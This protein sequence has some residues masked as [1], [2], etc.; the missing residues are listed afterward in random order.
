MKPAFTCSRTARLLMTALSLLAAWGAASAAAVYSSASA[1]TFTLISPP[2]FT[3]TDHLPS[4]SSA[5]SGNATAAIGTH[6][7]SPDGVHP[8]T[9]AN[10]VSGSAAY[11][12]DSTSFAEVKSGHHFLVPR[13]DGRGDP[14][15]TVVIP[16]TFEISWDVDL[17]I[18]RPGY[19]FAGGG[20][21][22]ALAGFREGVTVLTLDPGFP[23]HLV[24]GTFPDGS[25]GWE[26]N[27][28]YIEFDDSPV[29]ELHALTVSGTIT[30]FSGFI[31]AF[32]VITDAAGRAVS[33][34]LPAT[35]WLLLAALPLLRRTRR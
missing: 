8:A 35:V 33:V 5:V 7:R 18:T 30:V 3:V 19:E 25:N 31:G 24:S 22:F 9:V 21:Y 27:P 6:L 13:I 1:S 15:P 29:D 16:F 2:G 4:S 28:S 26:F 11:A 32:S 17:S 34:P 10:A 12:P 14:L 23:G 20:A